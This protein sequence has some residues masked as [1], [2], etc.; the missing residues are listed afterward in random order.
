MSP[1]Y[2][3]LP[4]PQQPP[5]PGSFLFTFA[6][7]VF[8]HPPA[9]LGSFFL[10][11]SWAPFWF[12]GFYVNAHTEELKD[13]V[14]EWKTSCSGHLSQLA[15]RAR[16]LS[17]NEQFQFHPFSL[18]SSGSVC[19]CTHTHTHT[20]PCSCLE[21]WH[22]GWFRFCFLTVVNRAAVSMGAQESLVFWTPSDICCVVLWAFLRVL[23]SDSM[24]T[25]SVHAVV[26]REWVLSSLPAPAFVL[27]I[28]AVL[29]GPKWSQWILVVVELSRW[30]EPFLLW[31]ILALL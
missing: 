14:C 13:R 28:I 30:R 8:Y 5:I 25:A 15:L 21:G 10:C 9:L 12:P 20:H 11:L 18:F 27:W 6:S 31:R 17:F 26:R 22:L 1:L 7:Y 2:S 16:I 24:V 3:F 19:I 4:Q 29:T 23:H